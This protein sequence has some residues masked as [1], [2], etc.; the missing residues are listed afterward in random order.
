VRRIDRKKDEEEEEEAGKGMH[1][2]LAALLESG[3]LVPRH[4]RALS[5][6]ATL[7]LVV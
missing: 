5:L 1:Q 3:M 2:I 7:H 4:R 6:N